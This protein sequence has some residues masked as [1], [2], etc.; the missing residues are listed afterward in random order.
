L[1]ALVKQYEQTHHPAPSVPPG[2]LVAHLIQARGVTKA[3]VAR[4]TAIPRQTITNIVN[5]T[6]GV[7]KANRTKLAKYFGISPELFLNGA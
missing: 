3:E 5:G 6:R 7:S 2:E 4:A 1:V